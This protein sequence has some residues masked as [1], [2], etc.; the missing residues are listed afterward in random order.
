[1]EFDLCLIMSLSYVK[2]AQHYSMTGNFMYA[3]KTLYKWKDRSC[4]KGSSP[5]PCCVW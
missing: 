1:M 5:W 3:V 2:A 4:S